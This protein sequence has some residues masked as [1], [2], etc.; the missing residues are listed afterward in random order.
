MCGDSD[1]DVHLHQPQSTFSD[2]MRRLSGLEPVHEDDETKEHDSLDRRAHDEGREEEGNLNI[3]KRKISNTSNGSTES[4]STGN[5]LNIKPQV[6]KTS[7]TSIESGISSSTS[8]HSERSTAT[9]VSEL[10]VKVHNDTMRRV[11]TSSCDA[12]EEELQFIHL[13]RSNSVSET[14]KKYETLTR[15][16]RTGL[17]TTSLTRDGAPP[18]QLTPGKQSNQED[19]AAT[20]TVRPQRKSLDSIGSSESNDC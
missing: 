16:R 17:D 11:S 18:P 14:V 20:L 5:S 8:K 15:Q 10:D 1:T 7:D 9:P 12:V 4:E 2:N 13:V 19:T 3:P 6:R